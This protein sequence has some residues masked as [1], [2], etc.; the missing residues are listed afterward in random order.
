MVKQ[1][2]RSLYQPSPLDYRQL[3]E[4]EDGIDLRRVAIT[5]PISHRD[6]NP[7]PLLLRLIQTDWSSLYLQLGIAPLPEGLHLACAIDWRSVV[8]RTNL[9]RLCSNLDECEGHSCEG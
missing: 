5:R 6:P 4:S 7:Q 1:L 3:N 9:K 8:I 2:D